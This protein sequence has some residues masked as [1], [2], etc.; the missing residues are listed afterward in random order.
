MNSHKVKV[1]LSGTYR[2]PQE[3]KLYDDVLHVLSRRYDVWSA[4]V[5]IGKQADQELKNIEYVVE[6]EKQAIRECDIFVAILRRPTP[7]TLMEIVVAHYAKKP[8]IAYLA[9]PNSLIT[10]SSWIKY[11]VDVMVRSEPELL[12]ALQKA[13]RN[14]IGP[15]ANVP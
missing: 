7:G 14:L 9:R 12:K 10:H 3:R 13:Q 1:F 8:S 11:H 6:T 5:K 4:I 15:K 2:S